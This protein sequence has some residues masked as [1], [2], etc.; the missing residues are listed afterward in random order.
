MRASEGLD[1]VHTQSASHLGDCQHCGQ[2]FTRR[3]RGGHGRFCSARCRAR[4]HQA[5]QAARLGELADLVAQAA[6]L[7][8][9]LQGKR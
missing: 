9:A 6:A 2:A 7:V 4:W 1:R 8:R 5:R 3:V